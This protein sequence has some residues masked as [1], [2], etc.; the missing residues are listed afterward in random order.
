MEE[1]KKES[2][3]TITNFDRQLRH[4]LQDNLLKNE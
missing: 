4:A 2:L 3:D 1:F